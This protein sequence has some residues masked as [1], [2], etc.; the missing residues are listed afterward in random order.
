[1]ERK[2]KKHKKTSKYYEKSSKTTNTK[3]Q[4]LPS[5]M[6]WGGES[7]NVSLS[8]TCTIDNGLTIL[9]LF[10]L[11][12]TTFLVNEENQ[13]CRTLLSIFKMMNE[14]SFAVAKLIWVNFNSSHFIKQKPGDK[15][16]MLTNLYGDETDFFM[17]AIDQTWLSRQNSRCTRSDCCEQ[18]NLNNDEHGIRTG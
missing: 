7:H 9:H 18:C 1:M 8:N 3:A 10:S 14:Q 12:H 5:V 6:K 16:A 17:Y 13:F 4:S 2:E 11:Q 15:E